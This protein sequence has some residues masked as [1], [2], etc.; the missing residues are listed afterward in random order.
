MIWNYDVILQRR[1]K[2]ESTSLALDQH[3]ADV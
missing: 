1:L 2:V 3:C